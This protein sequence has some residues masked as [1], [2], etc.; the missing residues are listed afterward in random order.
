M[1]GSQH[2]LLFTCTRFSSTVSSPWIGFVKINPFVFAEHEGERRCITCKGSKLQS[3]KISLFFFFSFSSFKKNN[4]LLSFSILVPNP[5]FDIL[6]ILLVFGETST[7][8][9]L[10]HKLLIS[11]PVCMHNQIYYL[12]PGTLVTLVD[13]SSTSCTS[14]L[15]AYQGRYGR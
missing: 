5:V 10:A 8:V 13:L 14:T 7:L 11:R 3:F 6:V 1:D 12:D 9:H 15:P 4:F 2:G